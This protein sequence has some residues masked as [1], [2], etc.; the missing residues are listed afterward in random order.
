MKQAV[1]NRDLD[2][3]LHPKACI[4]GRSWPTYQVC[5]YTGLALAILLA[6]IL[7]MHLGLSHLVMAG[8]VLAAVVTFLGLAT[9]TK[10][11]AGEERLTYYHH[12]VAVMVVTAILARTLRQ[13]VL[14]YLGVTILGVGM[15]LACGRVG[16]LMAGCCY[17]RPH[18]WG[19]CYRE[20]HAAVGFPRYLVG[21]RLFHLQAVES[22]WVLG[23]VLVGSALV[24]RGSPPGEA[25]AWY[26]VTYG[27]GRFCFEFMRGDPDRPYL[28]GFS[29]AQ[30]TSLV[31]MCAVVL[32]ELSG[33]LTFHPWHAG[34]TASLGL[35]MVAVALNRRF[36][37]TAERQL[38]HPHHVKEVAEAV[39]LVSS[40][41]TERTA[42]PGRNSTPADIHLACTS[43]GVQI[44]AGKVKSAPGY[45]YH[46]ALSA[47]NETMTQ[48]TARTLAELILQLEHSSGPRELI[49]GNRGVFH[50][51]IHPPTQK[52]GLT[53]DIEQG[54]MPSWRYVSPR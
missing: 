16:C 6:M 33:I 34:A 13:P 52:T 9:A 15:F 42:I 44:S 25:L 48:E 3:L 49:E 27:A 7:V 14:S 20:E 41:A 35:T 29:E 53:P 50:F 31:L 39:E 4:L 23:I 21:V 19:I 8:L 11:I 45:L 24:L 51:V 26:V 46:Y 43:L 32:A 37:G 28:W 47:Q 38:L 54:P 40:L 22:L 36:R 18:A 30:W 10:I 5:G 12:E 2:I 1:F 17:G